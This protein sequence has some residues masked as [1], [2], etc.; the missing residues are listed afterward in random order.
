MPALGCARPGRK[1]GYFSNMTT[2]GIASRRIDPVPGLIATALMFSVYAGMAVAVDFSRAAS[3]FHSDEATYYM[4]AHSIAAD[5][6]L[7]YRREDLA[8]VYREFSSGPSGVFLKKGRDL[9]VRLADAFPFVAVSSRP[10]TDAGQLFYGKSYLYALAAAPFVALFG[11]NGFLLL[12]AVLLAAMMLAGYLFLNARSSPL[13][14]ALLAGSFLMASVAPAYYVWITPELLNLALVMLG[15]FCWLFKEV[16]EPGAAPRGTRWLLTGRSDLLASLLLGLATFSKPSHLPL[17]LPILVWLAIRKRWA[18]MVTTGCVFALTG[19][20]LLAGSI[21]MTGEWN[22]QG[23]ERRTYYAQYPFEDSKI[24][25]DSIG[26][27]RATDGVEILFDRRVFWTHLSHNLLYF[28][29]GRYSGMLPYFF[30]GLFAV[31]AFLLA[32]RKRRPWQWLVFGAAV[33]EI[34]LLVIWI[35]DN[36]F[37]GGGAVGN[38]YFMG[39]YGVFLFLLPPIESV[40]VAFVPWVVGSLFTGAIVLNPF[41]AA[42]NPAEYAKQGP[43]RLLPVELTLVND[44]PVNT[45]PERARVWFGVQRRFQIYFLDDNAYAREDLSFWTR[46][47]S[48]AEILVKTVEPASGLELSV[49]AGPWPT[50]V[51]VARGWWKTSVALGVGETRAVTVP[52]DEGFPYQ[53]TRVW[54]VSISCDQGFVPAFI[55]AASSDRRFLGVRVTPELK[56]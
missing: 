15:Y 56:N 41:F 20:L 3:G 55:N 25:W 30:P 10:D 32:R 6:D 44:L 37:G 47:R 22:F 45:R 52:L 12:N 48:R 23:G 36:Y 49:Q 9:D 28:V 16:V 46:G 39:A 5:G 51:T 27:N 35:P 29:A 26:Q 14:A 34:L 4:M 7:A 50:T 11:T 17:I 21:V 43:V 13:V 33:A 8:R 38:R 1:V 19:A 53:G 54:H 2:S 24:A 18:S 42:F 31:G 40:L